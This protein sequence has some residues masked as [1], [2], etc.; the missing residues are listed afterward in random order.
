MSDQPSSEK[1]EALEAMK[2]SWASDFHFFNNAG[3]DVRE[4]W[5]VHEFLSRL[6]VTFGLDEIKSQEQSS[7][8]DVQFRDA[9]FQIKEIPDPGSRRSAEIKAIYHRVLAAKTIQDTIGTPFVYDVPPPVS[10]YE[11][12]R[13]KAKELAED[14]RYIDAKASLD[15]LLYVTRTRA[16]LV[17]QTEINLEELSKM[18]WRSVSCL[19]GH[20]ALVLF[21]RVDAFMFLRH[22]DSWPTR[23]RGRE[24]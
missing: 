20:R 2:R 9:R 19:M 18:G 21:G 6:S 5:V 22:K 24:S 17:K 7:K 4:R 12:V 23:P 10:G 14:P 16:T 13:D 1:D 11:L 3:K 8:V 15:L